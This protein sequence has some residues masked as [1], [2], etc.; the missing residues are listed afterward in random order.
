MSRACRGRLSHASKLVELCLHRLPLRAPR[1]KRSRRRV[2]RKCGASRSA[3]SHW[4]DSYRA[5]C[6]AGFWLPKYSAETAALL[7]SES[8]RRCQA[9]ANNAR[10]SRRAT[11]Q[12]ATLPILAAPATFACP[13]RCAW[14]RAC[15]VPI[16]ALPIGE[17]APRAAGAAAQRARRAQVL[18]QSARGRVQRQSLGRR[19]RAGRL[20]VARAAPAVLPHASCA[21]PDPESGICSRT[22]APDGARVPPW[23]RH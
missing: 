22:N 16:A 3:L 13:T 20:C 23:R 17:R 14:C 10:P 8:F 12:S 7:V 6:V 5:A 2:C 1:K 4:L 21:A 19:V 18:P 15:P 11:R 9:V